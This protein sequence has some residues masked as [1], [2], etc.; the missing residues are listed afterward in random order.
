MGRVLIAQCAF[1]P[2]LREQGF[3]ELAA[4]LGACLQVRFVTWL[5][6]YIQE[7]RARAILV[8]ES[9]DAGSVRNAFRSAN[10]PLESLASAVRR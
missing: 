2:P 4:R 1:D 3:E 5:E 9:A 8:F 6:S 7:D 10:V